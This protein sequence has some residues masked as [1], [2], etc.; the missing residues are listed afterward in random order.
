MD[1][2]VSL[3]SVVTTVP[4]FFIKRNKKVLATLRTESSVTSKKYS[5]RHWDSAEIQKSLAN[6]ARGS[7]CCILHGTELG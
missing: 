1:L 3:T 7:N 6:K 2:C 5:L 4:I